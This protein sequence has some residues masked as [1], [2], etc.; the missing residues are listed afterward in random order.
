[1]K[2]SGIGGSELN[3]EIYD[4]L[5]DEITA[6]K[7]ELRKSVESNQRLEEVLVSVRL[8]TCRSVRAWCS[9]VGNRITRS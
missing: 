4:R 7:R 1:M 2:A 8:G 5:D 9:S 6:A 3:R